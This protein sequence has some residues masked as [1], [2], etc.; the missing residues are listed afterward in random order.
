MTIRIISF[1][2]T[3]LDSIHSGIM[4]ELGIEADR[5]TIDR[6]H[7]YKVYDKQ[8]FMLAVIKY[9]IEFEEVKC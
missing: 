1:G 7:K 8:R 4:D 9:G 5:I 2:Q 3:F 6:N